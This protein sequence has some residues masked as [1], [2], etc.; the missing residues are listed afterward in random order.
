[1]IPGITS[2]GGKKPGA[3]TSVS[4]SAGNGQA[5]VSFTLPVYD[6]KGVATYQVFSDPQ[7]IYANG[8]SSPITITGLSNGTS[9][10]FAVT[11]VTS[12]CSNTSSF[13]SA[14][15][16]A[17][18]PPPPPPPGGGGGP[19]PPP[20]CCPSGG[21]PGGDGNCYFPSGCGTCPQDSGYCDCSTAYNC[22]CPGGGNLAQCYYAASC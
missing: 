2:S 4:A 1:M 16:P 8:A 5:T 19:P 12:C 15:T 22:C 6:G 21:N 13:S 18:P 17:A 11:T 10:T 7:A 20:N 9:Y 14:V 3:A